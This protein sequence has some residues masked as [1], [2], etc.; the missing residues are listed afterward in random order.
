MPSRKEVEELLN[1]DLHL[2]YEQRPVK[3][4]SIRPAGSMAALEA[5]RAGTQLG[6]PNIRKCE[7]CNCVAVRDHHRCYHHG[8]KRVVE[9]RKREAGLPIGS[10]DS[11]SRRNVRK[12]L[13]AHPVPHELNMTPWFQTAMKTGFAKTEKGGDYM[14]RRACVYLVREALTAW[15]AKSE[16]EFG[17]WTEVIQKVRE[18]KLE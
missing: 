14:F 12:F 9:R 17:P 1:K 10:T 15:A 16:G 4:P 18:L 11:V 2:T 3:V 13:R 5:H 7:V 6:G 8:G